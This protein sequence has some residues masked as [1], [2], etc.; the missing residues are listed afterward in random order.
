MDFKFMPNVEANTFAFVGCL[1]AII[2]ITISLFANNEFKFG[3][4]NDHNF[5]QDIM[6]SNK[7]DKQKAEDAFVLLTL[8]SGW[9]LIAYPFIVKIIGNKFFDT[10]NIAP[11]AT[12]G[13]SLI[14]TIVFA[15]I[16]IFLMLDNRGGLGS[17]IDFDP[18]NVGALLF[19]FATTLYAIV[20]IVGVKGNENYVRTVTNRMREYRLI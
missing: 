4:F 7:F 20:L 2:A 13:G 17:S 15:I 18:K 1:L 11:F 9:F 8:I 10:E 14:C 19:I 5:D 6:N 16:A 12:E 3:F